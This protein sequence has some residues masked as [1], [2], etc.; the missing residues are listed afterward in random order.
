M[1]P[2]PVTTERLDDRRTQLAL[3]EG[4][5]PPEWTWRTIGE[6]LDRLEQTRPS[7]TLCPFVPH[8][9]VR[10][11]VLGG[12][13]RAP[14]GDER[15][16]MIREVARGMEA[17]AWGISFGLVYT[18]GAYADRDEVVAVSTEAGRHGGLLSAHIRGE[19]HNLLEAVE[20]MIEVSRRSSAPVH[21]S[22]SEGARA[23][24]TRGSW[25]GCSR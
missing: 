2:A 11:T 10:D 7:I 14:T 6:Y 21:L 12:A 8:G 22:P 18:P 16:S 25:T 3:S 24:Q 9:A 23:S 15:R 5:G 19:S 20:E 13:Q 1:G 4:P 17:G